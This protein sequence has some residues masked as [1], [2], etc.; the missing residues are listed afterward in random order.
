MIII[1]AGKTVRG[2]HIVVPSDEQPI[3]ERVPS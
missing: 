3:A 1:V 2:V